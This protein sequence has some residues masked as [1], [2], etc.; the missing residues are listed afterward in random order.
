MKKIVVSSDLTKLNS[1]LKN[2]KE[3][4]FYL[5]PDSSLFGIED[6]LCKKGYKKIDINE[7][8]GGL[9]F[10]KEYVDF[11]GKLNRDYNSLHW[12]ASTISYKGTF[13]SNL[14]RDIFS[15]IFD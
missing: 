9:D 4:Y 13:A 6:F 7:G 11:I 3:E 10:R 15:F 14:Y 12:W 1:F 8:L 5:C 2:N